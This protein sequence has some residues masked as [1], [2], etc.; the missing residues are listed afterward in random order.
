MTFDLDAP[1]QFSRLQTVTL[2][3]AVTSLITAGLVFAAILAFLFL[4]IGGIEWASAGGDES[5]IDSA[6]RKIVAALLGLLFLFA[7]WAI[8]TLVGMFFGLN[9]FQLNLSGLGG[10]GGP[11]SPGSVGHVSCPCGASSV[12]MCASVGQVGP[13]TLGG[14]CFQCQTIGWQPLGHSSCGPIVCPLPCPVP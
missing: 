3:S 8:M 1:G 12:G 9:L 11:A 4:V 5:Q 6:K 2:P 10:G 14:L 13:L 7:I